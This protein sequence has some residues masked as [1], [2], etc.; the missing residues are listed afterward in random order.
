MRVAV[1]ASDV[2]VHRAQLGTSILRAFGIAFAS[3]IV[4]LLMIA[5]S[6]GE[7]AFLAP[8]DLNN[9]LGRSPTGAMWTQTQD[10]AMNLPGTATWQ[11]VAMDGE[12]WVMVAQNNVI[13]TAVDASSMSWASP[14]SGT[15]AHWYGVASNGSHWMIVGGGGSPSG[16]A[17][18]APGTIIL[19][20]D[21]LN[22][23][24]V[25][26]SSGTTFNKVATDGLQW[27]VVGSQGIY[28]SV[29]GANWNQVLSGVSLNGVAYGGG[30]WVAVGI[31]DTWTSTD[32]FTWSSQ[33]QIG[34]ND[35]AFNGTHW[36]SSTGRISTSAE[37][38]TWSAPNLFFAGSTTG[39]PSCYGEAFSIATDGDGWTAVV[40]DSGAAIGHSADGTTWNLVI[41]SNG[42]TRRWRTI[43]ATTEPPTCGPGHQVGV[44]GIPINVALTSTSL[45]APNSN[46]W[47]STGA[48]PATWNG[49]SYQP[50]YTNPGD[51]TIT[52]ANMYGQKATCSTQIIP[53]L[54]CDPTTRTV[55]VG[56]PVTFTASHGTAP[57][58]WTANESVNTTGD[59]PSFATYYT[60]AGSYSITLQDSG[61][62]AQMTTCLVTVVNPPTL[63]CSPG[64]QTVIVGDVVNA[65]ATGGTLPLTW[66]ASDSANPGPAGGTV[67]STYY[68]AAGTYYPIVVTDSSY[69]Q[70][71]KTCVVQVND[72][73]PLLCNPA[74]GFTDQAITLTALGGTAP[75]FWSAPDSTLPS[76]SSGTT[77]N[78]SFN[79]PGTWGVTLTDSS[80]HPQSINCT[81]EI[82]YPP[83]VCK[84]LTLTAFAT[85]TVTM[86]ASGGSGTYAWSTPSGEPSTG[87]GT[88]FAPFFT[89][90]GMYE[91]QLESAGQSTYC[92][93]E[94]LPPS[95]RPVG[96]AMESAPR[97][98]SA[99]H[100]RIVARVHCDLAVQF[101]GSASYDID[102]LV[103]EWQ[104]EFGDGSTSMERSP[105]HHYTKPGG[106]AIRLV[107][108]DDDGLMA[109]AGGDAWVQPCAPI[110]ATSSHATFRIGQK[111][112]TCIRASGGV[113]S[114]TFK[115]D[116]SAL[117]GALLD[118]TTGCLSWTP[119]AAGEFECIRVS[120][121]DGHTT[122]TS[123]L[124]ITVPAP[125]EAP[126]P[127]MERTVSTPP[128]DQVAI[129]PSQ[130]SAP[131]PP[132]A[133]EEAVA[134]K[135]WHLLGYAAM[136]IAAAIGLV[137]YVSRRRR[138]SDAA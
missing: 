39:C 113:G 81:V 6:P 129:Q 98:Y 23:N 108:K 24:T 61:P 105:L 45:G 106:Y 88:I 52:L 125:V 47:N 96:P 82:V 115:A 74:S 130:I 132:G 124:R 99:P 50:T 38:G 90:P 37:P 69:H 137:Y 93:V 126:P 73:P 10:P 66:T 5:S 19:S 92:M 16:S 1:V 83:P 138:A 120:A 116:I 7:A 91:V 136:A 49:A 84:L 127:I 102:G 85:F 2:V 89:L 40:W 14:S 68:T 131:E 11:D 104:W 86:Q 3:S 17:S 15:D 35:V 22:W 95:S 21:A 27:I 97:G 122:G 103:T 55:F 78:T 12:R 63:V 80:Y 87:S 101:D 70:Q 100:A 133:A 72:P 28:R 25:Y 32:G 42:S 58:A 34:K 121:T 41:N 31:L 59:Q 123:C 46:K 26:T 44:A 65:F 57:Y 36:I 109:M 60:A 64:D 118:S 62:P 114:L 29:D 20:E 79:L 13:R 135:S 94:V 53:A 54:V 48:T 9:Y 112:T 56:D 119:L 51:Y 107:V 18:S 77:F 30:T 33:D 117:Q 43:G 76:P 4:L 110:Q 75:Y 111:G 134:D 71:S 8:E 67:F 128:Y